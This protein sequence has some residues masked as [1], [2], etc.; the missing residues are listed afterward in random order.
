MINQPPICTCGRVM[1]FIHNN[2]IKVIQTELIKMILPTKRFE[3]IS[4][5]QGKIALRDEIL[6]TIN[7][8]LVQ[9][10]I[11]KIYFKEFVVQ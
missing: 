1:K 11:A 2:V 7:G 6:A 10:K 4:T 5:V 9:G 3:D 8:Y